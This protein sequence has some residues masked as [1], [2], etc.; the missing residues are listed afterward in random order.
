MTRALIWKEEKNKVKQAVEE[1]KCLSSDFV[2]RPFRHTHRWH[3]G[4]SETACPLG[5]DCMSPVSMATHLEEKAPGAARD[6]PRCGINLFES[7]LDFRLNCHF[8]CSTRLTLS[9]RSS[10][11]VFLVTHCARRLH[12][13]AAGYMCSHN[14]RCHHSEGAFLKWQSLKA[15][16]HLLL[17]LLH[18][19]ARLHA[20]SARLTEGNKN[21]RWRRARNSSVLSAGCEAISGNTPKWVLESPGGRDG[22]PLI[23]RRPGAFGSLRLKLQL[24]HS[25]SALLP[26]CWLNVGGGVIEAEKAEKVQC[27]KFG[28]YLK[29]LRR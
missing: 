21:G 4:K 11:F 24:N 29:F 18:L 1:W 13:R 8:V 5:A 7:K 27:V 22:A 23:K 12:A 15:H 25:L 16:L 9:G 28:L 19:W 10:V 2:T 14:S 6:H 17:L 26:G 3:P 20:R